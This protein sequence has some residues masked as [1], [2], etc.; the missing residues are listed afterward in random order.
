[1]RKYKDDLYVL[2]APTPPGKIRA[3][4]L[5]TLEY[6]KEL[7]Y[8]ETHTSILCI[9]SPI[10]TSYQL[11]ALAGFAIENELLLDFEACGECKKRNS[12]ITNYLQEIKGTIDAFQQFAERYPKE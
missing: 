3:N 5:E 8:P 11:A 9:T 4:T 10:Y 12:V 1:M 6:W 2:C 7:F